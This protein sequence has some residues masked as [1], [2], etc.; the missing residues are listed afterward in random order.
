M[1]ILKFL[2]WLIVAI[3]CQVLVFDHLSFYGG[4]VLIY[5]VTLVKMPV[6]MNRVAQ[7]FLGFL[8]GFVIDVFSN[9]PGMHSLAATT[10]MFTRDP[11]LHL[12]VNDPEYKSGSVSMT[13]IGLST[14]FRFVLTMVLMQSTML[15]VLEAF[16]LFNPMILLSKILIS[17]ALTLVM[18]MAAE[19]VTVKK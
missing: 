7:I 3:V 10:L 9:T 13:R 15:Y 12:Y 2:L 14:F 8:T 5:A 6:E 4:I 19:V 16:S 18:A 17:T 11:V 1:N